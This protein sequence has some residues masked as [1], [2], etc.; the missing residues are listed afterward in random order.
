MIQKEIN[1]LFQ[2]SKALL[3]VMGGEELKWERDCKK[4]IRDYLG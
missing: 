3:V 1:D 2:A 4:L